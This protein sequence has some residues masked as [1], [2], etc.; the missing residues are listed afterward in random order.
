MKTL[1]VFALSDNFECLE[2]FHAYAHVP[3]PENWKTM[4]MRGMNM[5]MTPDQILAVFKCLHQSIFTAENL[6]GWED[7]MED[8]I[9]KH[10]D[11]PYYAVVYDG[12]LLLG[13]LFNNLTSFATSPK[14]V[15]ELLSMVIAAIQEHVKAPIACSPQDIGDWMAH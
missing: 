5:Q 2:S 6:S 4:H 8:Y 7:D 3:L 10:P 11:T 12:H 1:S 13:D 9:A 15:I 14:E